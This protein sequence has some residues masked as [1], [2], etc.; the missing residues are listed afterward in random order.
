MRE[1]RPILVL[2]WLAR[3]FV[4][5][6]D[7]EFVLGDLEEMYGAVATRR[8][9]F[10]AS[11]AYAS[12]CVRSGMR[13]ARRGIAS[14][15]AGDMR[16]AGRQFWKNPRVYLTATI[17]LS[18][19]M[20]VG[21]FSWGIYYGGFLRGLP[22]ADAD[23]MLEVLFVDPATREPAVG[24]SVRDRELLYAALPRS[25]SHRTLGKRGCPHQ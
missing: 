22:V 5:G 17:V 12:W 6:P 11:V 18:V 2:R 10:S 1:R 20:G 25:G 21:A 9:T 13:D 7:S 16:L 8:G 15:L 24:F 23:L 19:G 14:G 3:V 4:R